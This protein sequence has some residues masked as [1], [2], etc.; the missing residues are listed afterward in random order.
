MASEPRGHLLRPR[1]A[2]RRASFLELFF[3]LAFI[4]ALNRVS[5]VLEE[6]LSLGG[7][8]RAALL[9]VP[10]WWVW[11]VTAW[12]TDWFDPRSPPIVTLL[13]W[14]MFGGL[15]MA[16]AAPT[17]YT[18]HALVFAGAYVAIHLGRPLIL[19]PALR[20]HPL[21]VRSLR[22]AI[23]F[24]V[25]GVLWV[26]GALA[27]TAQVALWTAAIVLDLVLARL[28]WPTPGL[29]RSSW[30]DL[31]VVGE[32]LA[33]RYQQIYII[34][35]GE[36]ILSAGIVFSNAGF[37]GYRTVA[38][39][40]AFVNAVTVGRLYL[41]PGGMR[42]GEAIEA[43][44]PSGSRLGLLAGYLHLVMVA[45]VVATAVG[46]Q[47]MIGDPLSRD[48]AALVVALSGP[49]LF[50]IGWIG[51][52]AAVHRRVTWYRPAGLAVIVALGVLA[53]GLPLL[54]GSALLAALLILIVYAET[55]AVRR[56][57]RS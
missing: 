20:G 24:G 48:P 14:V 17:A 49:A 30:R 41:V 43:R 47:V 50:L 3:D 54:A 28:R 36:L 46:A 33:E 32:H 9:L 10:I 8:Y 34:A 42:L 23:W 18:G 21:R 6:D 16:A 40:L 45:G 37:D 22:V 4:L 56:E 31:Q 12:S 29:G 26:T 38:F 19:L 1:E 39:A 7:A 57:V 35:L 53:Y 55:T 44:G 2:S 25:S 11:F 5:L 13:I 27:G 15:L 51:L 52:A